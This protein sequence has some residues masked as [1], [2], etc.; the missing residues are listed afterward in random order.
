MTQTRPSEPKLASTGCVTSGRFRIRFSFFSSNTTTFPSST[1]ALAAD[2]ALLARQ[3]PDGI[4]AVLAPKLEGTRLLVALLAD[5][6]LDVCVLCSALSAV[7]GAPAPMTPKDRS[8]FLAKLDEAINAV[9]R[10]FPP[11]ESPD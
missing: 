10:A 11:K 9:R 2:G 7:T 8:R 1:V 5:Q 3:T 6:P 4:A